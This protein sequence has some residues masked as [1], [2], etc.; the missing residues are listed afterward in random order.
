MCVYKLFL[1]LFNLFLLSQCKIIEKMEEIRRTMKR[2]HTY[3]HTKT[4]RE[5]NK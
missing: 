2:T 4:E 5:K 1:C 3:I